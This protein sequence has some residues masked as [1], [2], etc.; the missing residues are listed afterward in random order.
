MNP[1][2]AVAPRDVRTSRWLRSSLNPHDALCAIPWR[3]ESSGADRRL[4][5]VRERGMAFDLEELADGCCCVGFPVIGPSGET[6][7][8]VAISTTA[9]RWRVEH[10][11]LSELCGVVARAASTRSFSAGNPPTPTPVSRGSLQTR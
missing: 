10:E 3:M 5:A 2:V 6:I 8:A 11:R 4:Q 7:A 9:K 1:H